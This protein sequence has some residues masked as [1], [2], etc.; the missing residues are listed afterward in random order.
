MKIKTYERFYYKARSKV[1]DIKTIA[2]SIHTLGHY[3]LQKIT[4]TLI[5]LRK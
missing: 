4:R 3:Q 2:L 1:T 5:N